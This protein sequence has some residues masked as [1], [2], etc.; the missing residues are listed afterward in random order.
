MIKKLMQSIR[1]YKRPAIETPVF[2]GI[3]VLF[4]CALPFVMAQLIN[5]MTGESMD[6]IVKYGSILL[7]MAMLSLLFGVLAARK[8]ATAGAG[9][10]KNLRHDIFY[11]IQDF[12]FADVDRFSSSSLV[13]RLTTDVTNVQNA[14][15]MMIRIA[16]R[17]P[18]MMVFSLAMSF[19]INPRMALLFFSVMPVIAIALIWMIRTAMPIFRRIFKK[20]D[21]LNNSVQE[22]IAGIRVVK[23]FVREEYERE[24]FY[25][26]SDEVRKDFTHVERILALNSPGDELLHVRLHA[27]HQL[28]RCKNHREQPRNQPEHRRPVRPDFLRRAAAHVHHDA[29][30]GVRHAHHGTGIRA[31]NHGSAELREH[32][33]L[34]GKP[35]DGSGRRKRGLQ[36]CFF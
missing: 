18:L 35:G 10:A 9:F 16:V 24:K 28:L 3:E 31:K 8:A 2:V 25:R 30:H 29:V 21:A 23:S 7:V 13:T 33:A 5:H 11:A 26:A 27:A 4:E 6:P 34:P 15:Q 22:N 17:T 36:P 32:P 20:Y 1:D 19:S 14:F 12:S